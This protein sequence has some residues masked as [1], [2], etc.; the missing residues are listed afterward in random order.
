MFVCLAFCLGRSRF[1]VGII[2]RVV[3]ALNVPNVNFHMFL[4]LKEFV[5]FFTSL[6]RRSIQ[7]WILSPT[8]FVCC[9]R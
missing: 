9:F 6:K 2:M 8:Q 4:F 3:A 1:S 7:K 5:D